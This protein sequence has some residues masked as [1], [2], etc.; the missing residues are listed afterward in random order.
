MRVGSITSTKTVRASVEQPEEWR[1]KP[2]N[3]ASCIGLRLAACLE[4]AVRVAAH[5]GKATVDLPAPRSAKQGQ[6]FFLPKSRALTTLAIR[7]V[8]S[9]GVYLWP[10]AS[11]EHC[12][13][14]WRS[15]ELSVVQ[16]RHPKSGSWTDPSQRTE[17]IF[18]PWL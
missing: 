11:P 10:I 2:S 8:K 7:S 13:G 5:S 4:G 15:D 17:E 12:Y 16:R 3:S 6:L 1:C 9:T 18:N 14:G